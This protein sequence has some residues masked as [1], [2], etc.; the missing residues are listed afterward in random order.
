MDAS[1]NKPLKTALIAKYI[2]YC[3]DNGNEDLKISRTKM[4]EY[5]C[6]AW[7]DKNIIT[8]E[9]VYKSFLVTGIANKL[10]HLEDILFSSWKKMQKENPLIDNIL[11]KIFDLSVEEN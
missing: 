1:L 9:I 11:K 8:G 3:T 7:Y 4:V 10:E 5:I 6:Y 2:T